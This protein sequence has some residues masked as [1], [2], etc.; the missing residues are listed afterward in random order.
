MTKTLAMLSGK[1]RLSVSSKIDRRSGELDEPG[2]GE[3]IDDR[4]LGG[5]AVNRRTN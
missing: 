4:L 3:L 5:R 1:L 2:N